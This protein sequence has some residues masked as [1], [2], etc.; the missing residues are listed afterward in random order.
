MFIAV[1]CTLWRH[2]SARRVPPDS[3]SNGDGGAS[4]MGALPSQDKRHLPRDLG[5][6]L[7]MGKDAGR[8]GLRGIGRTLSLRA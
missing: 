2:F 4:I 3:A 7:G 5:L 6:D 1:W 8:E